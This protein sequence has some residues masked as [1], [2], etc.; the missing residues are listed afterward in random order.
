MA[1]KIITDKTG[2]KYQVLKRKVKHDWYEQRQQITRLSENK[3]YYLTD[4]YGN[5]L[6]WGVP[7]FNHDGGYFSETFRYNG[8]TY[9]VNQ[10]VLDDVSGLFYDVDDYSSDCLLTANYD[11]DYIDVLIPLF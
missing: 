7:N 10:F 5:V 9:S 11:G 2:K 4:N 3:R 8:K 1:K 6:R